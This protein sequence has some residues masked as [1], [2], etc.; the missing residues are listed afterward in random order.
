MHYS[1]CFVHATRYFLA[2]VHCTFRMGSYLSFFGP[3]ATDDPVANARRARA[4]HDPS[5][6]AAAARCERDEF[7][8]QIEALNGSVQTID[9]R[10]ADVM[11]TE[12]TDDAGFDRQQ[13][14]FE[15]LSTKRDAL[16]RR[17]ETRTSQLDAI[18]ASGDKVED[19]A[20]AA[21]AMQKRKRDLDRTKDVLNKSGF[22]DPA[23]TKEIVEEEAR[24]ARQVDALSAIPGYAST[25]QGAY[26]PTTQG[27]KA[28]AAKAKRAEFMAR[29]AAWQSAHAPVRSSVSVARAPA[30]ATVPGASEGRMVGD[31]E[32]SAGEIG[33]GELK[34]F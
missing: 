8:A 31:T 15:A 1:T 18:S 25:G 28:A 2:T 4:H 23:K 16:V 21:L 14:L 6:P 30:A 7:E 3:S 27:G 34:M 10:I 17:I 13:A 33:T 5:G 20:A 32:L 26:V 12:P 9:A 11:A 24:V 22:G 29:K 19:A